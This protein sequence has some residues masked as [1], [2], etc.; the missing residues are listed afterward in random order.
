MMSL[1]DPT[2]ARMASS[3][4]RKTAAGSAEIAHRQA[5]RD[6]QKR[7]VLLLLDGHRSIEDVA[8]SLRLDGAIAKAIVA[9]LVQLGLAQASQVSQEATA[10]AD[11]PGLPSRSEVEHVYARYLGPLAPMLVAKHLPEARDRADL[12]AKLASHLADES[13]RADFVAEVS[14]LR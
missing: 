10:A 4:Y 13:L 1:A 12:I 3:T 9:E 7:S 14:Q 8:R 2:P 6:A 5:L 11:A